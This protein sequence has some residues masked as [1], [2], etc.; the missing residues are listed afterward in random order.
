LD[1]KAILPSGTFEYEAEFTKESFSNSDIVLH[2]SYRYG[3]DLCGEKI[4][5]LVG[6][7]PKIRFWRDRIGLI[8]PQEHNSSVRNASF[9]IG[10]AV[11]LAARPGDRLYLVRTGAGGIGLSLLRQESL[12]LALGAVTAVPLGRYIQTIRSPSNTKF[13][14]DPQLDTWLELRV[15]NDQIIL[16]E[17]EATEL[18][19]Y[20]IYMEH[21]WE[22]G[23]PGT[24]EC[25]SLTV[26]DSPAIDC[27]YAVRDI[28]CQ[29]DLKT[30]R[31]DCTGFISFEVVDD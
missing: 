12:V 3:S 31:W 21:G 28:G 25:L 5:R 20:H 4:D 1:G 14:E 29:W 7:N 8:A 2:G 16:R 18:G 13:W 26:L 17:R 24:D 30:T 19:D 27:G 15:G 11:P 22:N 23:E 10:D 9:A 6:H